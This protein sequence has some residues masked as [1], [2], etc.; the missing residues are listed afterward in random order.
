LHASKLGSV[1]LRAMYA[2]PSAAARS[3]T[4]CTAWTVRPLA[5]MAPAL[6]RP[7]SETAR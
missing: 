5:R 6:A 2:F 1:G 7:V 4:V 3:T